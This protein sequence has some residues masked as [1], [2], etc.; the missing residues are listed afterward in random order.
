MSNR[1]LHSY[2]FRSDFSG[3]GAPRLFLPLA[4]GGSWFPATPRLGWQV[5]VFALLPQ[6]LPPPLR[7]LLPRGPASPWGFL[8][9][10]HDRLPVPL[11]TRPCDMPSAGWPASSHSISGSAC[12]KR[13][14][15]QGPERTRLSSGTPAEVGC[16]QDGRPAP[17]QLAGCWDSVPCGRRLS[18]VTAFTAL[19]DVWVWDTLSLREPL[20]SRAWAD[21]PLCTSGARGSRQRALGVHPEH[22]GRAPF[23]HVRCGL[24]GGEQLAAPAGALRVRADA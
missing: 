21:L 20:R 5:F 23:L 12:R 22:R 15:G 1:I 14:L 9:S 8:C 13:K 24:A 17:G 18:R 19:G 11:F 4:E 10:S 16:P 2:V 3:G 6:W 7:P